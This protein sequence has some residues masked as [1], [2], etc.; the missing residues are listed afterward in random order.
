MVAAL[1]PGHLLAAILVAVV[2]GHVTAQ[3]EWTE[4]HQHDAK[5]T[6]AEFQQQLGAHMAHPTDFER[7]VLA[8]L[9]DRAAPSVHTRARSLVQSF[10]GKGDKDNKNKAACGLK[11]G[12]PLLL[13]DQHDRDTKTVSLSSDNLVIASPEGA[14]PKWSTSSVLN[15]NQCNALVDFNVPNKPNPP[16]ISLTAGI[17]GFAG[18]TGG[19]KLGIFFNDNTGTLAPAGNILNAWLPA[20]DL[21]ATDSECPFQSGTAV[22]KDMGDGD[23]K[24]IE[25]VDAG[26]ETRI[27]ITP[28]GN[29]Q[30]WTT[31]ATFDKK[32]CSAV[33]DFNVPGK[34]NP[35][36][37]KPT[38]TLYKASDG[39]DHRLVVVWSDGEGTVASKSKPL[40][41]WIQAI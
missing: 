9:E 33:V 13:Y 3:E 35:P 27:T 29:D 20:I 10:V 6:D 12:S 16:P 5:L 30:S 41:A 40:N 19:I 2:P 4:I 28:S 39:A 31:S 26:D 17:Y 18:G 36:P 38:A 14:E 21:T 11:P 15:K 8:R 25:L 34:P 7:E 1:L 23:K 32:S 22:F 24:Q 37:I